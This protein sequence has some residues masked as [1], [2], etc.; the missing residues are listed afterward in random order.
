MRNSFSANLAAS[1]LLNLPQASLPAFDDA[2]ELA[3]S[4]AASRRLHLYGFDSTDARSRSFN[5]IRSR[6]V[7]LRRKQGW[8]R[9]GIVSAT[10]NV[11]KS[12]VAGNLAAAMSRDPRFQ[13]YL[14]DLDLRRGAIKDLFG[15]QTDLGVA[16]YLEQQ[17][18]GVDVP[19]HA[20]RLQGQRL[21][22]IPSVPG[23]LRSSEL[24]ASDS[25]RAMFLA[26]QKSADL[27]YFIVDLP[28]AFA[29]DDAST[30][31][32]FL[33]GYVLI[34]EEGNTSLSEIESVV[35]MLGETRL[36]GVVLNKYRGGLLSE[37]RGF[38]ERYASGYYSAE[39]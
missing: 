30:V 34:A 11:G 21:V 8:R 16:E 23:Y 39:D 13:T 2:D 26:V 32:Q 9:I 17:D 38:E 37:G 33:D 12:F 5:L 29:N 22:I 6:L 7:E 20:F 15:I 27:N 36:A 3:W 35:D 28:P 19:L 18:A 24:L 10:P 31:L 1:E 25:A 4:A 14:I